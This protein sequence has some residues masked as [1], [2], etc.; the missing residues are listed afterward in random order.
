M[1]KIDNINVDFSA[2]IKELKLAGVSQRQIEFKTGASY[3][4]IN[5]LSSGQ[6]RNPTWQIA[7]TVI[8]LHNYW[9]GGAND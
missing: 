4:T 7:A 2:L 8:N 3:S 9:C 5:R 6:T 1:N